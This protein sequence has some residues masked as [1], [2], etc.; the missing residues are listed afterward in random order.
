ME[1]M[2]MRYLASRYVSRERLGRE[3]NHASFIDS[4]PPS[5]IERVASINASDRRYKREMG[6]GVHQKVTGNYQ[7]L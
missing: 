2:D 6:Q 1:S 5:F 7:L 4:R 3:R